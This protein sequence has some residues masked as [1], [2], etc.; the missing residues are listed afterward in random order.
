MIERT[1]TTNV[2]QSEI[3][4]PGALAPIVTVSKPPAETA[5]IAVPIKQQQH[6]S[7]FSTTNHISN[8]IVDAYHIHS[9]PPVVTQNIDLRHVLN[10]VNNIAEAQVASERN[11]LQQ[12]THMVKDMEQRLG[13][14]IHE[15]AESIRSRATS[16]S[17]PQSSASSESSFMRRYER[18]D[19][20]ESETETEHSP[21]PRSQTSRR[22]NAENR[23]ESPRRQGDGLKVDTLIRF[24]HKFDGSGDLEL[25][26]TLYNK[27]IMSNRDLS[28]EVKYAVLLNH[29][30]GPAQK[31]V[32]R[33]QDTVLAIA[34]TFRF[35]QQSLRQSEQQA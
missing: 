31:C 32:S 6:R 11:I 14:Q 25:F 15:R 5:P 8:P 18:R 20:S 34:T 16:R 19:R 30:T 26:Q 3:S 12:T 27:F 2:T 13:A 22:C 17:H 28:A 1:Q 4:P 24:L 33:A 9:Q 21:P 23:S 7:M 35:T 10:A 29:I